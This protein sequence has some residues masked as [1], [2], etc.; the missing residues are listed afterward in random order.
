MLRFAG[1]LRSLLPD[2]NTHKSTKLLHHGINDYGLEVTIT[3]L[4]GTFAG[5]R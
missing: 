1:I 2:N 5:K 4:R 3:E